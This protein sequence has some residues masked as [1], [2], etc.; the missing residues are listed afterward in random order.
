MERKITMAAEYRINIEKEGRKYPHYWEMCIGTCHAATVLREDVRNQIRK[1]HE[2]CGFRYLRFH[3]LFDDDMSVVIPPFTP[4]DEQEISFFNIDSIFDFL[5][6]TGMKPFVELGF[7]P[8]TFA[9]GT[10]TCFHYKGNVTMP[11]DDTVW[12]E[13]IRTFIRHLLER[14]GKEEVYTWYFEVWNEP[15][16]RFFF[17]GTMEDYF[18][19]YEI[20]VKAVKSVD[21]GLRVGGPATSNNMWIPEFLEF[22]RDKALPVD[23]VTTHHYPNDDPLSRAGMNGAGTKGQGMDAEMFD[24]ILHMPE[25]EL[26]KMKASWGGSEN[27]NPRDILLR[28]AKKAKQEAGDL[29]LIYTEWNGSDDFD[30]NYQAAFVL[31]TLAY[32][33][34]LVEGYSYWTVTDIFE[35]TGLHGMPFNNEFGI[36]T[37]YGIAK[38][39]YRLFQTLHEAGDM[40]LEVEGKPHRTAEVFALAGDS[41]VMVFAYNHDISQRDIEAQEMKITIE[42]RF[43]KIEKAVIDGAHCN[44]YNEW[45]MQG[46]PLYP[47]KDQLAQQE[48]ASMLL[49]ED[50]TAAGGNSVEIEFKA[51]PENV[52]ILRIAKA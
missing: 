1:A 42:G 8:E 47:S 41:E 13:F 38:P 33:E 25:E 32:N 26:E 35:E 46:K 16:L 19:L 11:K 9:S 15:N 6:D 44:P 43:S 12:Q 20:T 30:N 28:C 45:V 24:Q 5:L 31:Q 18:H 4:F 52:T 48:L 2:E 37:V 51:E 10:Q 50:Y 17:D 39:V 36:Q 14:Y 3:G 7:M 29:P 27:K 21:E 34:G 22:C 23:F 40:R 49:Y